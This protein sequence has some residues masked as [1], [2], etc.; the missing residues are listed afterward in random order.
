MTRDDLGAVLTNVEA[1]AGTTDPRD[2]IVS[3]VLRA[4]RGLGPE[5]AWGAHCGLPLFLTMAACLDGERTLEV[6]RSGKP[7]DWVRALAGLVDSRVFEL[8]GSFV[9]PLGG[10]FFDA[11]YRGTHVVAGGLSERPADVVLANAVFE[12]GS[13][14]ARTLVEPDSA[15]AIRGLDYGR[16]RGEVGRAAAVE[17]LVALRHL[18]K[19][20]SVILSSNVLSPSVLSVDLQPLGLSRLPARFVERTPTR[21][22]MLQT[23]VEVLVCVAPA[24]LHHVGPSM[25]CPRRGRIRRVYDG[26]EGRT[27]SVS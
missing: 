25:W 17:I 13:G 14:I 16:W 21:F 15:K 22:G 5:P 23:A 18:L 6:M 27:E 26:G 20:G 11:A 12:E 9:E 7:T 10:R 24:A 4:E 1:R 3:N 2:P 8:G 19:P